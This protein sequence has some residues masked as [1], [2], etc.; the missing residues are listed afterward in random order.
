[1]L[2][3]VLYGRV[4]T[5]LFFEDV[6]AFYQ[7]W[8]P[9]ST[10]VLQQ[11]LEVG[12]PL[13]RVFALF[14]LG[15]L[16]YRS[17]LRAYLYSSDNWERW[18]SAMELWQRWREKEALS[19]LYELVCD[20]LRTIEQTCKEEEETWDYLYWSNLARTRVIDVLG[21]AGDADR[22][23]II[24]LFSATL[25]ECWETERRLHALLGRIDGLRED[26]FAWEDMLMYR[27]GQWQ[28]WD[29]AWERELP[30][31]RL[32]IAQVMWT[33]GSLR[34]HEV[35]PEILAL[36]RKP[37]LVGSIPTVIRE[38]K[39]SA[40]LSS[41]SARLPIPE[42][43]QSQI[44]ERS[45]SIEDVKAALGLHFR[46]SPAEQEELLAGFPRDCATRCQEK[47]EYR[48]KLSELKKLWAQE[49]SFTGEDYPEIEVSSD[50]L[51]PFDPPDWFEIE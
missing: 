17:L 5:W 37:L 25:Q 50:E 49:F 45:L 31:G 28:I 42:R 16:G 29:T 30:A 44:V 51:E 36:L 46:L 41:I 10:E 39:T 40:L 1:M 43:L 32:R 38:Q 34:C 27:L 33:L 23:E 8:A 9:F 13:E 11:V 35:I 26:L 14:S 20:G 15:H 21:S 22:S 19:V 3:A 47:W 12:A 24:I 48:L 18:A 6:K 2:A 4:Q 7:R